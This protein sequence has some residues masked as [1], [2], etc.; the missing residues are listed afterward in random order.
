MVIWVMRIFFVQFFC[1]SL[2]PLLNISSASVQSIP[3]LSFIEP[4]FA[5]NVP[6]LSYFLKR[7][8]VFPILLFSSISLPG[9]LRKA[10]LSLLAILWNSA[11]KWEY[12]SVSSLPL[13]SLFSVSQLFVRPSQR[14]ISHL[15]YCNDLLLTGLPAS[16]HVHINCSQFRDLLTCKSDYQPPGPHLTQRKSQS[17]GL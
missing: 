9:S 16:T 8:I 14:T 11:F 4:I 3:F 2:P 1:V 7:S 13:T 5:R 15:Y 17:L 10:F 6:L 12:L